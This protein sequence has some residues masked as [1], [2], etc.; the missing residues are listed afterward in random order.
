MHTLF[1]LTVSFLLAPI[2]LWVF[3]PKDHGFL[4]GAGAAALGEDASVCP[5][6]EGSAR[7]GAWLR[8][9]EFVSMRLPR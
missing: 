7:R 8:G 2:G 6:K 4:A 9:Y 5:Y 1:V 3:F